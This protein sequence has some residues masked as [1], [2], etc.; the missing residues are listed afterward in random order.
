MTQHE[1]YNV[2]VYGTLQVEGA[3]IVFT[4]DEYYLFD[5][6]YP[7][8]MKE[9]PDGMSPEK[10]SKAVKARV[11]GQLRLVSEDSLEGFDSYEGYHPTQPSVSNLYNRDEILVE[12]ESDDEDEVYVSAF[13]YVGDEGGAGRSCLARNPVDVNTNGWLEWGKY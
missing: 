12:V 2:F 11:R 3:P 4:K 9:L 10:A 6:A 5:G 13:V 8:L 7:V 1:K